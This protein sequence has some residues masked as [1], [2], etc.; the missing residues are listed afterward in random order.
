MTSAKRAARF[1]K[2]FTGVTFKRP[3]ALV[4][5][6]TTG[7][8]GIGPEDT[9]DADYGAMLE[10]ACAANVWRP[11]R[12]RVG[13]RFCRFSSKWPNC[14]KARDRPRS[15]HFLSSP[16]ERKWSVPTSHPGLESRLNPNHVRP[17]ARTWPHPGREGVAALR[18]GRRRR[19]SGAEAGHPHS[20]ALRP[21][22]EEPRTQYPNY[23]VTW[24]I[25]A[26]RQIRYT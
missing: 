11:K 25:R 13:T 12:C 15:R 3:A 20:H 24:N 23:C 21:D 9:F 8:D 1:D 26:S 16:K 2:L 22:G 17:V 7:C 10:K 19:V 6:D 18:E 14:G 4:V 5:G